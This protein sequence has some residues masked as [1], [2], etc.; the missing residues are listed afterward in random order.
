MQYEEVKNI[1]QREL[2]DNPN[3]L[4]WHELK[5]KTGLPYKTFCP[6]WTLQLEKEIGLKKVKGRTR[7]LI[8]RLG[9]RK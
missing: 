1:I 4:T 9:D 6:E 7:A 2:R 8:W 5:I 3:G